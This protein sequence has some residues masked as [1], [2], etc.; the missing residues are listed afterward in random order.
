MDQADLKDSRHKLRLLEAER[1][2]FISKQLELVQLKRSHSSLESKRKDELKE[3]DRRIA[4]LEKQLLSAT[5]AKDLFE[6]KFIDSKRISDQQLSSTR[7]EMETLLQQARSEARLA[8]E[9]TQ[10]LTA[11]TED[12]EQH[13]INQLEERHRLLGRVVKEYAYL[14]SRS[15]SSTDYHHLKHNHSVLQLRQLRLERKLANTEGQVIELTHLIRQAKEENHQLS[16]ALS[17]ALDEISILRTVAS[18][19][20]DKPIIPLDEILDS[21]HSNI[22]TEHVELVKTDTFTNELLAGFYQSQYADL[23]LAFSV[24]DKELAENQL[25]AGQRAIDLENALTFNESITSRLESLQK[26]QAMQEVEAKLALATIDDLKTAKVS[27][28]AKV[29]EM[30]VNSDSNQKK[31]KD[32]MQRLNTTIQKSRMAEEALREEIDE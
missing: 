31:E 28:E 11:M 32:I 15:V 25:T 8:K 6:T 9:E 22:I 24:F 26:E 1:D 10:N 20:D 21:I 27:L 14:A 30:L 17:D 5:K 4:D 3:R 2:K 23:Y 7:S 29:A 16:Q 13:V 18:E 19:D 12:R